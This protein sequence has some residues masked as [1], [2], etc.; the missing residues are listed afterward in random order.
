MDG[1]ASSQAPPGKIMESPPPKE[2]FEKTLQTAKGETHGEVA[3]NEPNAQ[4]Q[5]LDS[6]NKEDGTK[7]PPAPDGNPILIDP[8]I[9]AQ[10]QA[11]GI[12]PIVQP[13]STSPV[14]NGIQVIS[15]SAIPLKVNNDL[16]VDPLEPI[17][18][19]TVVDALGKAVVISKQTITP[20]LDATQNPTIS[21]LVSS[22]FEGSDNSLVQATIS[23]ANPNLKA[24]V[25]T[26]QRIPQDQS[27]KLN[28]T[29]VQSTTNVVADKLV[30]ENV[31]INPAAANAPKQGT[32]G[33]TK[34]PVNSPMG[35]IGG[36]EATINTLENA[37]LAGGK[38][39]SQSKDQT[40]EDSESALPE[41]QMPASIQNAAPTT[42]AV[43]THQLTTAERQ[44]MVDTI[45]KR[46]DELAARS[47]RNEVRVEM[48]P[49]EL[50]SVV[51]NIRKDMAGLTA[52]LNASNEPLRQALHESRNDLAG[53]LAN[54]NFG[55][56][57]IE[58]RGAD[59]ETMNMGQQFNQ[60][61]SNQN[62]QQQDQQSRQASLNARVA[63]I[64]SKETNVAPKPQRVTTALLDM[65]I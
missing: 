45:S 19:P 62:Q 40:N 57:K 60:A 64:E 39:E 16:K 27:V 54:R 52:T 34:E 65:E 18:N 31:V 7:V 9:I 13:Q 33:V 38:S 35:E 53:T 12:V 50:G 46:I 42:T 43:P 6:A 58:V 29:S 5:K 55:Q 28:I 23:V 41:P 22:A 24:V 49:A 32:A 14:E 47:V 8:A 30:A 2:E 11:A 59:A 1:G 63:T 26:G 17:K 61:R 48:H 3:D 51:I 4:L 37:S 15:A 25:N 10:L 56:V 36:T 21:A 20:N 44:A